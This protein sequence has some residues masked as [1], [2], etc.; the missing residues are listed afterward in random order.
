MDQAVSSIV[1]EE[2]RAGISLSLSQREGLCQYL[3]LLEKWGEKVNLTANPHSEVI[4]TRHLPDAL[5]LYRKMA[6]DLS[7][8][9]NTRFVDVG[10]GAGLPGL[11]LGI[12]IPELS[13]SLVE[14][15]TK[16]CTFMRTVCHELGL[17]NVTVVNDRLEQAELPQADLV[18]SR[19]TWPPEQWLVRAA[20]LLKSGGI[21]VVFTAEDLSL[22]FKTLGYKLLSRTAYRLQD[23]A[24]RV[25]TYL[26]RI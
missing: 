24:G 14:S 16:K 25:Q 5:Y 20:G 22:D 4:V 3:H 1:R 19:A 21:A 23:G 7:V 6:I 13:T 9:Q 26:R 17:D 11:L 10:S 15:I 2:K 12:L 18:T 8:D